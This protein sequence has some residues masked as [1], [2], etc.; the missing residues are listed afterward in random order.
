M[1]RATRT[2]LIE[3]AI[4][5]YL[6]EGREVPLEWISEYLITILGDHAEPQFRITLTTIQER[7]HAHDVR[8]DDKI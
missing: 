2:V 5:A 6:D 8:Q 7:L 1:T 4:Q 3:D